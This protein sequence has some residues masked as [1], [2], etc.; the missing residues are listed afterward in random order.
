MDHDKKV[1][2]FLESRS[3]QAGL[4]TEVGERAPTVEAARFGLE[5]SAAVGKPASTEMR[6]DTRKLVIA[7]LRP[8]GGFAVQADSPRPE[9][10][11]TYYAVRLFRLGNVADVLLDRRRVAA[12]IVAQLFDGSRVDGSLDVDQLYYGVRGLQLM[13]AREF[14]RERRDAVARYVNRCAAPGGGFGLR[15]GLVPDIERTYCCV[16][17]LEALGCLQNPRAHA[18]WTESCL[19]GGRALWR[20]SDTKSTPATFYWALRAAS[21]LGVFVRWA[22]VA[23]ALRSFE[24]EDGGYGGEAGATLWYTYCGVSVRKLAMEGG[25]V[26]AGGT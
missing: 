10:S 25:S 14:D 12:W 22:E 9:L 20:P 11:A 5:A 21:L 18:S 4:F 15:P 23:S 17:I 24:R 26:D 3:K 8:E 13:D 6:R 19:A 7:C 2:T 1:L 16:S